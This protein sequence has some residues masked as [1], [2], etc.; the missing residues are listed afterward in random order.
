MKAVSVVEA[1]VRLA[2]ANLNTAIQ[3]P[4]SAPAIHPRDRNLLRP[5][6]TLGK[7]KNEVNDISFL[8]RTQYTAEDRN[9]IGAGNTRKPT[10]NV[11]RRKTE[12]SK[13]DP[14]TILRAA[15][16]GFDVANPES[17]YKGPDTQDN[18]RG[19]PPS[20]AEMEAWKN[21]Q[22]PSQPNLKVVDS[23]P[24]MPDLEAMTDNGGYTVIKLNGNPTDKLDSP[25]VRMEAALLRALEPS[26]EVLAEVNAKF[27]AFKADPEHNT[28]PGPPPMNYEFF[29]PSDEMTAI[30]FKRK[31]D[32]EDP[33]KDSSELYTNTS[34]D[35]DGP[36]IFRY[37]NV[38]S[39]ETSS[40]QD[41]RQFP[42]AEIALALH[43]PKPSSGDVNGTRGETRRLQKAAYYYPVQLKTRLKPRRAAHLARMGLA[44]RAQDDPNRIDVVEV[45]IQ[46]PDEEEA[47]QRSRLAEEL[48]TKDLVDGA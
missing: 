1:K 44:S 26:P 40:A 48:D 31:F 38:R 5:L 3:A 35:A 2:R 23:Y 36:D 12:V 20:L 14:M 41:N 13:E 46:D 30:N 37:N 15:I 21:P 27:E 11:K 19:L 34:Q 32:V 9:R 10:T 8:R 7:P 33:L 28:D 45:M 29:L 4:L 43:D 18:I 17:A 24:I 6:K 25:D 22:H 16:K 47:A 39:Y 42:Y